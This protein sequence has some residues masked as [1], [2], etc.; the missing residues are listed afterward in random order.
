MLENERK[1]QSLSQW[2]STGV[3]SGFP[4]VTTPIFYKHGVL[5]PTDQLCVNVDKSIFIRIQQMFQKMYSPQIT[6]RSQVPKIE[7]LSTFIH[8][9]HLK[10]K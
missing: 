2:S 9:G 1:S 8:Y 7:G 10:P 4:V 6:E 5:R 3:S